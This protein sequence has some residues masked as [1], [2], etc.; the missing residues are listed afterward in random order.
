MRRLLKSVFDIRKGE[1]GVTMLMFAYQY[2]L[3]VTYYFLK[4]ARDS[5]F[6]TELGVNQLPI[7]FILI[8]FVSLPIN[9]IYSQASKSLRLNAL[10]NYTTAILIA[11]LLI[12][13]VILNLGD[14]WVFY[15]FYIWVS[16]YGVFTTAQYWLFANAI[17]TPAQAKRIFGF[18]TAGAIIGAFTGGEVTSII[19]K[20][21]NV[22]TENLL[23][24]CMGFLAVC[25]ML[26]NVIWAMKRRELEEIVVPVV[27]KETQKES[28]RHVF[29]IL[30]RSRHLLLI[31]SIISLTM[32]TSSFVDFQ[33]KSVASE[34]F[35]TKAD[36]TSFM[37]QFYGR[38]SLLSLILQVFFSYRILRILGVGGILLFLPLGLFMGSVM[39]LFM[40]GL[41]AGLL[42]R[43]AD[44][45]FR[46]SLDKM[47]REILFLPVPLELKKH[48]KIFIDVVV[49]RWFR[50]VAG[51][52]L[53]LFVALDFSVRSYS[54][55]V[56]ILLSIWIFFVLLIRKEY[57][58]TF[59]RALERRE[60][61]LNE[62]RINISG[63]HSV[64]ALLD[65]L[66]SGNVR[67]IAY[68]MDML[69]SAKDEALG[70]SIL[71]LVHHSSAEIRCKAIRLLLTL[72]S[73]GV[74]GEI[75]KA[76]EDENIEVRIEALHYFCI[77]AGEN[78]MEELN[79]FL[80]HPNKKIQFAAAACV[81]EHGDD[82]DKQLVN[83]SLIESMMEFSGQEGEIY[84]IQAA[85]ILG[86]LNNPRYRKYLRI[87][88]QDNSP[89][90]VKQ[91]LLSAG[92]TQDREFAALLLNRL[93]DNRF[94][95]EARQAIAMFGRKLLGTMR[96]YLIDTS[97]DP[98]IRKNIPRTM[99]LIPLQ[100]T[101]ETLTACMNSVDSSLAYYI[102]KA[103]NSLRSKYPQLTIRNDIINAAFIKETQSYFEVLHVLHLRS[104]SATGEGA[105]LFTRALQEKL[106]KNLER[107]FRLLGLRYP[108][109]DI[110]S[111]YLGLVSNNKL[112]RSSA[113]EFLDNV[114]K[115]DYKKYLF[116]IIDQE[117]P[118][119]SIGYGERLFG[120]RMETKY[121]ALAY[122]MKGKDDW[123]KACA[124]YYVREDRTEPLMKLAKDLLHDASPVVRETAELVFQGVRQ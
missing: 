68:S 77:H 54:I 95:K 106:G 21:F 120:I 58:N 37:G 60:I 30:G 71:P 123:L 26:V 27:K 5:L 118:E 76:I 121:D 86:G 14:A 80:D 101:V 112:L 89:A 56:L 88:M 92:R 36:L 67:Q 103:L 53:L 117:A 70:A 11:C 90:V 64:K 39:M 102:I 42:L 46:Y 33:F 10:I 62:L 6:L 69:A 105:R 12:L 13:R 4:P 49:D 47:G 119:L 2:L 28:A 114:L 113:I 23:Y 73:E 44:G 9:S 110:Y 20:T 79:A 87:L 17:Y 65:S 29:Q 82:R 124:L 122:I 45:C 100:E 61:D 32:A 91:T 8:A 50:G 24:F 109:A 35:T 59:R 3:L 115:K 93:S 85:K 22:A 111:A 63:A 66:K 57:I 97:I 48:T 55:V 94:R 84:R 7:V 72:D 108:P 19:V 15:V 99:A 75:E 51:G 31:V 18:L 83:E 1:F 98:K 43:G 116:P 107:I 96:D 104:D 16:I 52:L 74:R 25:I 34:A 81:A 41:L 78:R 38:V 40:P